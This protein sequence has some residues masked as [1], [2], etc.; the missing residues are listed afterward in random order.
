[1]TETLH[2]QAQGLR[3]YAEALDLSI[4][5]TVRAYGSGVRPAWVSEDIAMDTMLRDQALAEAD[6]IEKS[7]SEPK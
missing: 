4:G 5:A 2:E 3:D 7:S 6:R 1:M